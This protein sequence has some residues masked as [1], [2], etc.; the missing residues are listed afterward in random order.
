[1]LLSVGEFKMSMREKKE[2]HNDFSTYLMKLLSHV[3]LNKKGFSGDCG[4]GNILLSHKLFG[5][6]SC[7]SENSHMTKAI[8][9]GIGAPQKMK[10]T[11]NMQG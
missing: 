8:M 9:P 5:A 3:L 6:R 2:E 11:P 1:M 10:T 4:K 7:N